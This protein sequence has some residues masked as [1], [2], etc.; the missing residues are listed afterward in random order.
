MTNKIIIDFFRQ[1]GLLF[2]ETE[3]EIERFEKNNHTSTEIPSDWDNPLNVIKRGKV[4]LTEFNFSDND[5][6]IDEFQD[7]RMAA[8]KG[9]NSISKETLEKMK[10]KHKDGSK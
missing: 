10:N 7:L 4:K 8:R 5:K 6:A 9:E 3:E 1:K 2:P